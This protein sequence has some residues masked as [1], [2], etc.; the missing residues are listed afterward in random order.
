MRRHVGF[1]LLAGLL[2]GAGCTCDP[3]Y[4]DGGIDAGPDGG[5]R[6][7]GSMD[8][9][10]D[11]GPVDAGTDAGPVDAGPVDAGTDAGPFD[12]GPF[13]AGI[14]GDFGQSC[15]PGAEPCISTFVCC[16]GTCRMTCGG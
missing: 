4:P 3:V 5:A 14:C 9:G 10:I 12:A 7:A 1:A 8:G 2:Y 15:C 13:D 11:A 6:D 16:D